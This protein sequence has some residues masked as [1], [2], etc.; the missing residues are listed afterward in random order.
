MEEKNKQIKIED[1]E[2]Y[3]CEKGWYDKIERAVDI[4]YFNFKNFGWTYAEGK[5][6]TRQTITRQAIENNL[7][8]LVEE[9][10]N[11]EGQVECGRIAV[12]IIDGEL[13]IAMAL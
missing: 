11:G 12:D 10:I 9:A 6:I 7:Y 4:I 3:I 8:S 2:E 13:W 1:I 5:T